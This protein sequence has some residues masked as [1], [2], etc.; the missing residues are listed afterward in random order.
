MIEPISITGTVGII[1]LLLIQAGKHLWK[2]KKVSVNS[3]CMVSKELEELPKVAEQI[4][5]ELSKPKP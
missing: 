1:L 2:L 4:T 3:N 5:K